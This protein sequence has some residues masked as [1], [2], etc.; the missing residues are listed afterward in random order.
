MISI[1]L[2]MWTIS[3]DW[4][5]THTSLQPNFYIC[6]EPFALL[7][8][9]LS[10]NLSATW[11]HFR[12]ALIDFSIWNFFLFKIHYTASL[13][14]FFSRI[15]NCFSFSVFIF[16]IQ[17][18]SI[19]L[20]I[21]MYISSRLLFDLQIVITSLISQQGRTFRYVC[22]CAC[23]CVLLWNISDQSIDIDYRAIWMK[24]RSK[25]LE[26]ML[27]WWDKKNPPSNIIQSNRSG[28]NITSLI[29][30]FLFSSL[31]LLRWAHV[32]TIQLNNDVSM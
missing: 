18:V 7:F 2:Q 20:Y 27:I 16:Y 23:V 21:Y 32:D 14:F 9:C 5:L 15:S 31:F 1:W 4:L 12:F 13:H 17:S 22:L 28:I 3:I 10:A 25:T 26:L 8:T 29:L 11:W 30:I 6:S 24:D 19:Y